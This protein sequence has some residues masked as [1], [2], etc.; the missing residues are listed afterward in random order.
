MSHLDREKIDLAQSFG[1]PAC[2]LRGSGWLSDRY[3]SDHRIGMLLLRCF[4]LRPLPPVS[5]LPL[6]ADARRVSLAP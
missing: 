4:T 2:V 6:R 5:V 1:A 3:C